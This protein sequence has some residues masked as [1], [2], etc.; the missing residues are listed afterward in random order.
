VG[1]TD[2]RNGWTIGAG[3]E[4]ALWDNLSAK[5]EYNFIDLGAAVY[6]FTPA[7]TASVDQQIHAVKFGINYKF[8]PSR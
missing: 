1:I 4:Y 2:T 7:N 8:G 5:T 6:A 3:I